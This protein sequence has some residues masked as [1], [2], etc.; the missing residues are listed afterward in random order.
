MNPEPRP[1]RLPSFGWKEA[2][3][4]L[5]ALI[6]IG[7][8]FSKTSLAE[9][10]ALASEVSLSWL[11]LSLF[12]YCSMT[13]LKSV[14][15]W[16]LLGRRLPYADVLRIVVIQNGLSNLVATSAGI[17]TYLTLFRVEQNVRLSRS[18]VVFLI[19]K[20][21]DVC[22]MGLFLLVS[23][24]MVWGRIDVLQEV[25]IFLLLVIGALL[26]LFL[27][28][29]FLRQNFVQFVERTLRWTRLNRFAWVRGGL[30]TAQSL[31]D[32]D[33]KAILQT[34]LTSLGLAL[35][36]M[37]LTMAYSY[38]RV[39]AFHIP[40]DFW[41][42][43]F[44]TAMIQLVSLIP[45]QAFGG[46]GVIEFTSDYLYGVFGVAQDIPAILIGMRVVYYL[47][48]LAVLLYLPFDA[49]LRRIAGR[50]AS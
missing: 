42:I 31:A 1:S 38:T 14:Q 3:R 26:I 45:V 2:L 46:L 22:S 24:S 20:L 5:L 17:A 34:L 30:N 10:K 21:G 48:N 44:I 4:I 47:F 29:L 6:L 18:G 49:L 39:Q 43:L 11:G 15:Y 19:T 28:A 33:L 50:R 37:T 7:L 25:V 23:A 35:A 41:P 27:A 8:V 40:I 13:C 36:Y 12:F 16:V 9:I 32:N